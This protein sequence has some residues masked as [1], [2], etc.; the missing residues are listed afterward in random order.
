MRF[1]DVAVAAASSLVPIAVVAQHTPTSI[2]S[3]PPVVNHVPPAT[4]VAV[5]VP[6]VSSP[7]AGPH[8]AS[9]PQAPPSRTTTRMQRASIANVKPASTSVS[10]PNSEHRGL[11]S[12]LRKSERDDTCKGAR[13]SQPVNA[14]PQLPATSPPL[15]NVRE[16]RV[17]PVNNPA[18]PCNPV[19]PCCP[20]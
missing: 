14:A 20:Y 4:P 6:V 18:V 10:N 19:A 9:A 2:P 3:P 1:L 15:P 5:R 11:F 7:M 16:C 17:V 12:F 8:V 13:C